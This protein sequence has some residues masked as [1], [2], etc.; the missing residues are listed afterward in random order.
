MGKRVLADLTDAELVAQVPTDG[1]GDRIWDQAPYLLEMQRRQIEATRAFN[2]QS[3]VQAATMIRLTQ[4]I[5]GLTVSLGLIAAG[6][7]VAAFMAM[8]GTE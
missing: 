7:L 1:P 5:I 2:E 4:W 6:Q 8:G 3:S